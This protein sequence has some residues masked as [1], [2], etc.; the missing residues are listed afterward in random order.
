MGRAFLPDATNKPQQVLFTVLAVC[1]C[2]QI[3]L[4]PYATLLTTELR[5]N[6]RDNSCSFGRDVVTGNGDR[7]AAESR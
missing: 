2:D 4:G 1:N 5:T 6:V 7:G 3:C